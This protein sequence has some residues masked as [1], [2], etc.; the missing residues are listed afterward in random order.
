MIFDGDQEIS[1]VSIAKMFYITNVLLRFKAKFTFY[2]EDVCVYV[3]VLLSLMLIK[4][5]KIFIKL[6]CKKISQYSKTND[7]VVRVQLAFKMC[8]SN[9]F[10]TII[11]EMPCTESQFYYFQ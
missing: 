5:L 7:V 8:F 6:F 1:R 10:A 3:C 4:I 9:S 11:A 2:Q